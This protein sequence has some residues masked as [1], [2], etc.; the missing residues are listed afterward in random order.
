MKKILLLT[1][2]VVYAN[3]LF[4]QQTEDISVYIS[5]K[6]KT[7]TTFNHYMFKI[8]DNKL[9]VTT[10]YKEIDSDGEQECNQQLN[11][12]YKLSSSDIKYL[13]KR[14]KRAIKESKQLKSITKKEYKKYVKKL[15]S[16]KQPNNSNYILVKR[17]DKY[18]LLTY[19][20]PG[21]EEMDTMK[22]SDLELFYKK[23]SSSG[24][25]VVI[26]KKMARRKQKLF[27]H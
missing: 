5:Q 20:I 11:I 4:A 7:D 26:A 27:R 3:M 9:R 2:A 15:D 22:E 25:I 17:G 8:T 19:S 10:N 21:S 16:D 13:Q 6:V 18:L 12:V 24:N 14:Y 1:I 23:E